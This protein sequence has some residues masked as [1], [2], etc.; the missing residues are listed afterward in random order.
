MNLES[1][2]F[3]YSSGSSL[4]TT[5]CKFTISTRVSLLHFGQYSGK[6]NKTV[7]ELTLMR[8]LLLQYGQ[9]THSGD[10]VLLINNLRI[11]F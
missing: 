9:R 8:V 3:D 7:S 6:F 4:L 5:V 11:T 1:R 2:L 10:T